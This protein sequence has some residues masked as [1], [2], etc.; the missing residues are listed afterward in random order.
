M[1]KDQ[2]Q[3]EEARVHGLGEEGDAGVCEGGGGEVRS[4]KG[5]RDYSAVMSSNG[6]HYNAPKGIFSHALE[7]E[8][9]VYVSRRL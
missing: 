4:A 1:K 9:G 3:P 2:V 6:R 7:L 5:R 8:V